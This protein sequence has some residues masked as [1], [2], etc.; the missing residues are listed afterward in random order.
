MAEARA[1]SENLTVRN[2]ELDF[3]EVRAA[4]VHVAPVSCPVP[5]APR[6]GIARASWPRLADRT[7]RSSVASFAQA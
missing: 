4:P 3:D 5:R 1:L 7:L 6:G 2:V